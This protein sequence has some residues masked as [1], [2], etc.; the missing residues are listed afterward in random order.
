MRMLGLVV[1]GWELRAAAGESGRESE[2]QSARVVSA[3]QSLCVFFLLSSRLVAFTPTLAPR[4]NRRKKKKEAKLSKILG[5]PEPSSSSLYIHCA[6][7]D[8]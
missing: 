1:S 2:W 8:L 6:A 7:L 5:F 3:T 4:E